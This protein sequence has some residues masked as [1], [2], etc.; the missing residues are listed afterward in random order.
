MF[1]I[2]YFVTAQMKLARSDIVT[3]NKILM[4]QWISKEIIFI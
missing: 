3:S 1:V 4:P 2:M